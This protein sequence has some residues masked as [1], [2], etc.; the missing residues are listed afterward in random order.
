[1]A[2]H[3]AE[4]VIDCNGLRELAFTTSNRLR[5]LCLD[6]M[7]KGIIVVP[8]CVWDEFSDLFEE[9]AEALAE[10]VARKLRMNKKYQ[11][12]AAAIA[13]KL[14][15]QFSFSPHDMK[16]DFFAAAICSCEGYTLLTTFTQL[17]AYDQMSCCEYADLPT[18]VN[19][20][21]VQ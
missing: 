21:S 18:W 13:D 15:S 16:S 8:V 4:F 19:D 10:F 6:L 1:M 20:Y 9:E 3:K 11:I 12:G 14:N 17:K 7:K 2:K 5:S